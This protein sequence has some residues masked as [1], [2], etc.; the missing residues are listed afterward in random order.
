MATL[1]VSVCRVRNVAE[2]G[3]SHPIYDNTPIIAANLTTSGTAASTSTLAAATPAGTYGQGMLAARCASVDSGHYVRV[4]GTAA[5]NNSYYVPIGT[6]IEIA[7][8]PGSEI[9]A[10]TG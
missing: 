1:H 8:A 3:A 5:A 7:F 9:S 2:N 6:V 10:I 4:G